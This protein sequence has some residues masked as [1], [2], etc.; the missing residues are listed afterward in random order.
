MQEKYN[1]TGMSCAACSSRVQK[2]VSELPG[3]SDCSVNLLKNSMVVS[4]DD[5]TLDSSAIIG[6]VEKAGY[7]AS[8]Q[9]AKSAASS[10]ANASP[11]DAAK[12]EYETMKR[13][14]IWSFVFTIPLFYIS[15]GHMMG[16]PLPGFFHGTENAM[17][18]A[19]TLFILV[20]PVAIINNKYYRIGFKTLLHRSPNMDSLI[21][22][23]SG[24]SLLYGV[25]ALYKIAF[26]L[27]HGDLAMVE[28]F[29]HDLYF[30][31]AG[32]ILTLIT[33]GKFFEARAKGRTSDAINKLLNLAPKQATVLRGGQEV[34]IPAEEVEKGDIL[35][36][37]AG[38]SIPVDGVLLDGHGSVD[39]SAITGESIPVDKASGDKV[40]GATI[41]QSGYFTMRADKVGDE[42]AL[43]QIIQLVDEATSSKAPIAKLADKIAG[44]FVPVVIT[45]AVLSAV[46]W[47]LVGAS[48]EFALTIAV[49][50]L[51][52][53]CP[54]ALGLATPTAIMVGTGRGAANGILIKSAES[55]ETAHAVNVVVMDKTG[56]I[57]QGK[58]VVTDLIPQNGATEDSL[59]RLAASLEKLSEHPLAR[60]IAAEAETR[61]L[62]LQ[63]VDDFQQIPGQG[64]SG[65]MGGK[66]CLAGNRKLMQANGIS[67]PD[68][69]RWQN[70]LAEQGK[71]PLFFAEDGAFCGMIAVADV[72]KPT[73][74]AAVEEL[75]QMGIDVVM[76]TGDHAKTAEAIRQQVGASH[77][78]AEVLPQDKERE[79]RRLQEEGKK[80]A[81]VGDGIND[82]PALARADVGIAIGAGTD[83]AME[84]ADI[85]LMKNDL[86]DVAG[87]I[88]LS[89]ATIR[90]IKQNL[91]W[92]FI[93]NII[94]IP[95]AA[96]C[97]YAA[98]GLKM[99]PMVAALAMSFSSVFVVS[100]ALRLRFFKPKYSQTA[101]TA[102]AEATTASTQSQETAPA[103]PSVPIETTVAADPAPATDL[104][105]K[106][107]AIEGMM[108]AHCQATVTKILAGI[109]GAQNVR[110]DLDGKCADVDVPPS[111]S[112]DTLAQLIT[113]AGYDVKGITTAGDDAP[114]T[115]HKH[116]AIEGMMCA[117]CQ[118]TVTKI[119]AGIDGAQNVRVDLD[120]KCADVDVPP[121]VSD[122]TLAQLITD[123]GYD[124]KGITTV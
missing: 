113:D 103:A 89:K 75:Q 90:N 40:I 107:L 53:S 94:G 6:A 12:K 16:W 71:T 47:L 86:L 77:V 93:Y 104:L 57:T 72:V 45:I 91:F 48:F 54:C 109:D 85:V 21:A 64:I 66:L 39:E 44:V 62:V 111:V 49:S 42:T 37:K 112:D 56:T 34:T 19:L 32:T 121:S 115:L 95:I 33:L 124:V 96:G 110:V 108:C 92:A 41:N 106:H 20:L 63:P 38:E 116:L 74:K 70:T 88:E 123:A 8:L 117:H 25:Y 15:M 102:S 9:N 5:E 23:G 30:E 105:H 22:L 3:V 13:R 87:A 79:I 98:I 24:A 97:F 4:Y 82:A 36:V 43:A 2:S 81:M 46:V 61:Q 114:A 11:V 18:Y 84:S 10:Q 28:Q 17:I 101:H 119:L 60:A 26:G 69:D 78:I 58:P 59:L 80:V 68:M 76:L 73:S 122:D 50:V 27:G 7:G 55:L 67:T 99:N 1:V 35:I 120:G 83:V 100:N 65:R 118:A 31:G 52:V 29:S 51:V 14:V